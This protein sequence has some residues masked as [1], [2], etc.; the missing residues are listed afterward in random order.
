MT[1]VGVGTDLVDLDRLRQVLD[2]TPGFVDRVFTDGEQRYAFAARDP[3]ERLG[4]R[5]AVKE[6]AMKALGVGLGEVRF[7]DLEVVRAS[8]GAPS[9]VVHGTGIAL[10]RTRGVENWLISLT[11]T[12][13]VAHAVVLAIGSDAEDE[14]S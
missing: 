10:A 4:A 8:S 3:A 9:L 14:D 12:R 11:H 1:V 13:Q 2:R 7:R 6:A 5:F